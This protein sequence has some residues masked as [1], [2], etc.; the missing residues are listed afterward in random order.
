MTIKQ[1]DEGASTHDSDVG[2]RASVAAIVLQCTAPEAYACV[3]QQE[4]CQQSANMPWYTSSMTWVPWVFSLR[5]S[6]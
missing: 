4:R 2:L 1:Q 3:Q 6:S 5:L